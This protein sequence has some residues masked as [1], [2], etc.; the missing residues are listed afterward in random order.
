MTGCSQPAPPAY[1]KWAKE[2][3]PF[4][5]SPSSDNAFDGY[6]TAAREA[7]EAA[8][9]T[10]EDGKRRDF[11]LRTNVRPFE[12]RMLIE[13]LAPAARRF[14]RASERD[15][16][17]YFAPKNP[18]E[19]DS[20]ERGWRMIRNSLI[21]QIEFAVERGDLDTAVSLAC[22]AT[23]AGFDL[24]G[25]AAANA[26]IGLQ[27]A[28][29][30]RR[31]IAPHI[32][33]LN[34]AQLSRLTAGMKRALNALPEMSQIAENEKQNFLAGVD[35]IQEHYRANTLDQIDELLGNYVRDA[36]T[37]LKQVRKDDREKRPAYFSGFAKEAESTA[38]WYRSQSALPVAKR[39]KAETM[40]LAKE[41]PWRRYAT[42]LFGTLEP[43]QARYDATLART[44]LMILA[45]EVL[46]QVKIAGVAPSTLDGFTKELRT[47][48]FSGS[49]FEYR[50]VGAESMLYSV[51]ANLVDDQGDTDAL[52]NAPDLTLETKAR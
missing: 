6:V 37:H 39:A 48:P 36:T 44:R 31:A 28:D 26:D 50:A 30:A 35:W 1:P 34:S 4:A 24:T 51:G 23:K 2:V 15:C 29:D 12:R 22:L 32:F 27:F 14:R 41:R 20:N 38:D 7:A 42:S 10:G 40:P 52:F 49:D 8:V 5:P 16:D 46:R 45:G 47:D 17:F 43:I 18:V 21:W 9:V 11:S 25:G 19:G 13:R 33:R 3:Q